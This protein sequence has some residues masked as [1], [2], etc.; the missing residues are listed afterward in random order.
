[1][2][3]LHAHGKNIITIQ[4]TE[5]NFLSL[6]PAL[7]DGKTPAATTATRGVDHHRWNAQLKKIASI[8]HVHFFMV[9]QQHQG[10]ELKMWI[11]CSSFWCSTWRFISE[12]WLTS[13][14]FIAADSFINFAGSTDRPTLI[15]RRSFWWIIHGWC[16]HGIMMPGW[17]LLPN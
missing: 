16:N 17:T 4:W 9:Q 6:W 15:G 10:S 8:I 13:P 1:M 12:G 3:M 2:E 11:F 7:N 5:K 14:V